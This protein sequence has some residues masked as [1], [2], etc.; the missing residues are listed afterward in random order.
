MTTNGETVNARAVGVI[1][2]KDQPNLFIGKIHIP[3]MDR[4]FLVMLQLA[5]TF[6]LPPADARKEHQ[7]F[8]LETSFRI[9]EFKVM[10]HHVGS[11][12]PL[13]EGI[14]TALDPIPKI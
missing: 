13:F 6:V 14:I 3:S 4:H 2:F 5:E 8:G 9:E 11:A 7:L 10:A 1:R 12:N